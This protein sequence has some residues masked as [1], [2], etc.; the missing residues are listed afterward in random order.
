LFLVQAAVFRALKAYK[1]EQVSKVP[2]DYRAQLEQALK[3]L[4]VLRE[5]AVMLALMVLKV[6]KEPLVLEFKE[7]KVSKELMAAE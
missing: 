2:V 5:Q 3:V 7:P 6:L 4:L 1:V